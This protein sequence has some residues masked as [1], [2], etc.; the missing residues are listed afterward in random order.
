VTSAALTQFAAQTIQSN[1]ILVALA[2]LSVP[3]AAVWVYMLRLITAEPR[4]VTYRIPV[5]VSA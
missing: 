3:L 5:R 4:T 1:P 2:L